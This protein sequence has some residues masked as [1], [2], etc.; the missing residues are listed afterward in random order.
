MNLF[1]IGKNGTEFFPIFDGRRL[2]KDNIN[3]TDLNG[4]YVIGP[5][6]AGNPQA[7]WGNLVALNSLQIVLYRN[8]YLNTRA[9]I[10]ECNSDVWTDW[11]GIGGGYLRVVKQ[12]ALSILL[13]GVCHEHTCKSRKERRS[14]ESYH[15]RRLYLRYWSKKSFSVCTERRSRLAGRWIKW[16]QILH[17]FYGHRKN[18]LGCNKSGWDLEKARREVRQGGIS[19]A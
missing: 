18:H 15:D 11:T 7:V 8:P 16:R 6:T 17:S 9:Y 12:Y 5:E 14:E 13:K 3:D 19:Y 1:S 4:I 10:R 2:Y